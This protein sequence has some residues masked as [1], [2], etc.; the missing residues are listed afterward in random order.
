MTREQAVEFLN[1][2]TDAWKAL[3]NESLPVFDWY[4]CTPYVKGDSLAIHGLEYIMDAL[5]YPRVR[6]H[7][8]ENADQYIMYWNGV[9]V[10]TLAWPARI[11]KEVE[12]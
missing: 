1:K 8:S 2:I 11:G 10:H 6:M 9:Q 3:Q 4:E 5:G 7:F 12:K